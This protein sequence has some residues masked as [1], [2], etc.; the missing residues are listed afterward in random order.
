MVTGAILYPQKCKEIRRSHIINI[1][2]LFSSVYKIPSPGFKLPYV[3]Y[4]YNFFVQKRLAILSFIIC[5]SFYI[6]S[7]TVYLYKWHEHCIVPKRILKP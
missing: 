5:M 7:L 4:I 3:G 2:A 6:N 1:T